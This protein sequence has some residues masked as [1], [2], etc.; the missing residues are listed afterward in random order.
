MTTGARP[1]AEALTSG[2]TIVGKDRIFG[3]ETLTFA[4]GLNAVVLGAGKALE[5]FESLQSTFTSYGP[6]N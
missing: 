3:I 6:R 2:Q 1:F 5:N 4:D